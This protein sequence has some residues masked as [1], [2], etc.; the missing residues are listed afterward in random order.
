MVAKKEV[1]L[2]KIASEDNPADMSTESFTGFRFLY[3][4]DPLEID[5]GY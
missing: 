4:C 5:M 1:I 3:L 2:E